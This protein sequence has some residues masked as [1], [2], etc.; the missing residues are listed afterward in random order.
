MG[1]LFIYLRAF[2]TKLWFATVTSII[3]KILDLM[4]PLLVAWVIDTVSGKPP[5]WILSITGASSALGQATFLAVLAVAIFGLESLFQWM[6]QYGFFTLAQQVQHRFRMDAYD[7]MQHREMAF[8]ENHRLGDT[9]AILNDDIN[10]LERFMNTGFSQIVQLVVVF[11]FSGAVLFYTSWQL[12]LFALVPIPFI[13]MGSFI[14]Q[15]KIS[16]KYAAI[17]AKVGDLT[18]RIENNISGMMVIKSFTAEKFEFQRVMAAS[19]S[20]KTANI[21]AIRLNAVYVPVIRMIIAVAFSGIL[22]LGSYWIL[23]GSPLLTIGEL[24]LFSML[25]QR[26]LWPLTTIGT[27]LDDYER[28]KASINRVFQLLDSPQL[29]QDPSTPVE[30]TKPEGDIRFQ[31]IRFQYEVG[32]PVLNGLSFHI[33]P[34]QTVGIAGTTGAGKSTLVKLLFRFYDPNSG[35]ICIDNIP[36]TKMRQR[37][38]RHQIALVSQDVYLFYGSIFDN[39]AYGLEGVD[40][41]HV[42]RAAKLARLDDFVQTLPHKYDTFVGEKGLK[43]S[44][45][46]RQR[47]SIARAILKDAPIMV[48]DEATSS[49]DTETERAIKENLAQLTAG[50]TAIVIAH[51]LSTITHADCI[52]VL[53][54]GQLKEIGTHDELVAANGL[55]ADLWR[56]QIGDV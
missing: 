2:S 40:L 5:Q 39:I 10:Q 45:G 7:A 11:C 1:R 15:S 25:I 21:N 19:E 53:G 4:P 37:D 18:S 9:L 32:P 6:Y 49:V 42:Q 55:Y 35:Q 24:V 16:P 41:T 44:G 31:D 34:N 26:M 54:N 51:R 47:L 20:Y 46:Q 23:S 38:L 29:I 13:L 43:L 3:N 27:V 22:L 30:I 14:Y 17:R 50:K 48:F 52:F 56:M 33:R 12:S 8:F 36:I 28:A